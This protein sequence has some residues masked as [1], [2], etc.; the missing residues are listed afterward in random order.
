MQQLEKAVRRCSS[1][2]TMNPFR[3]ISL[4][5]GMALLIGCQGSNTADVSTQEN[6]ADT[7]QDGGF[8]CGIEGCTP[9][10]G[11]QSERKDP[12]APLVG[13]DTSAIAGLWDEGLSEF[14][15]RRFVQFS[16]DGK[17]S[18]YLQ[19]TP[20]DNCYTFFPPNDNYPLHQTRYRPNPSSSD[21]T[22][23]LRET[24]RYTYDPYNENATEAL[25]HSIIRL[26]IW[27]NDDRI[28]RKAL[29][30]EYSN[31][32]L[33][34]SENYLSFGETGLARA[35]VSPIDLDICP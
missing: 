9:I 26:Q 1:E 20:S 17:V 12:P 22:I 18:S 6:A 32:D 24:F 27:V 29:S 15:S 2:N 8:G 23:F 34:L 11:L 28:Y 35:G 14:G 21:D 7:Q 33:Q 25:I 30:V 19:A 4:S 10:D 13:G 5:I 16:S 31:Y 3:T